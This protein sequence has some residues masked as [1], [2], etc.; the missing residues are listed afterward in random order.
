M[1]LF[2]VAV[3][4]NNGKGPE[5]LLKNLSE[6]CLIISLVVN[7]FKSKLY[8]VSRGFLKARK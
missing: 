1:I 8:N 7:F 3:Q 6:C 2:R 5:M 4:V